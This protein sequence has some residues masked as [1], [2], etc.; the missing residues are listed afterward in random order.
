MRPL[1]GRAAP[2]YC[3]YLRSEVG[4]AT[5]K[6]GGANFKDLQKIWKRYFWK[7]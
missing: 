2:I 7:G 6:Y 3:K 1:H 4:I 5:L